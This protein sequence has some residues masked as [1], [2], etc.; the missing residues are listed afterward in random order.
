MPAD[1]SSCF[2]GTVASRCRHAIPTLVTYA[3][4]RAG[5]DDT[6]RT[7]LVDV[8]PGDSLPAPAD[9]TRL[10]CKRGRLD[11][12]HHWSM[13]TPTAYLIEDGILKKTSDRVETLLDTPQIA[14]SDDST[15]GWGTR[16]GFP[17][18][19]AVRKQRE[20]QEFACGPL[21]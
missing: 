9:N 11:T 5:S 2:T 15:S 4:S 3:Y 1:G 19:R 12:L 18:Y 16:F 21:R 14:K 7:A 8:S 6:A 20:R 17:D 13:R 10:V